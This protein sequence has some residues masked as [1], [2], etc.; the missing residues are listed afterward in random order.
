M[1]SYDRRKELFNEQPTHTLHS[2][3][4]LGKTNHVYH[5][6]DGQGIAQFMTFI[7]QP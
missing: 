5:I 1:G 3:L 4:W 2:S 6:L 7:Q